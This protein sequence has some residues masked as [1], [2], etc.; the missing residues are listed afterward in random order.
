MNGIREDESQKKGEIRVLLLFSE[1]HRVDHFCSFVTSANVGI[2]VKHVKLTSGENGPLIYLSLFP[3]QGWQPTLTNS[4]DAQSSSSAPFSQSFSPSHRHDNDTHLLVDPPQSNFSGGQVC[5]PADR[6]EREREIT[7]AFLWSYKG[8]NIKY[9]QDT[10]GLDFCRSHNAV[11][12]HPILRHSGQ[13]IL[14]SG[15]PLKRHAPGSW[16]TANAQLAEKQ[17]NSSANPPPP[18]SANLF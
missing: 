14:L 5:L 18:F 13:L 2:A 4:P 16:N 17:K 9:L 11:K 8:S 10:A 6:D 3:S 7:A 15:L 1:P 12:T